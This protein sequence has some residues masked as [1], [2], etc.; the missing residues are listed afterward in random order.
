MCT[1][2]RHF[3]FT[4]FFCR[5]SFNSLSCIDFIFSVHGWNILTAANCFCYIKKLL[6]NYKCMNFNYNPVKSIFFA[7]FSMNCGFS[8]LQLAHKP[9]TRTFY[10]DNTKFS[11]RHSMCKLT[12]NQNQRIILTSANSMKIILFNIHSNKFTLNACSNNCIWFSA[13]YLVIIKS[14]C[15]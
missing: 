15:A 6:L 7:A 2:Q 13:H 1:F 11:A 12:Q 4:L 10:F 9:H 3:F 5:C 8:I 14:Q